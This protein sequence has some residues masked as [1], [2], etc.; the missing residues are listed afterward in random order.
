MRFPATSCLLVLALCGG[1]TDFKRFAYAGFQ[2]Y[3]TDVDAGLN[4]Y[5]E[6]RAQEEGR[7]NIE[8]VLAGYDD[9]R[10]PPASIDLLFT[11]NTYHHL[12]NRSDY[13]SR[14]RQYLRPGGR[15]AIIDYNGEGWFPLARHATPR[16]EVVSEM[17]EAGYRLEEEFDFLPKQNFLVFAGNR[18]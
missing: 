2:V 18:E 9:P 14:A 1:C 13:F 6:E 10:L 8:V 15:V 5:L 12:E 11:C 17:E 3:A 4:A 16:E 7:E